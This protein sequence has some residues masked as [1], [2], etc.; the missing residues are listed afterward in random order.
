MCSWIASS[1]LYTSLWEIFLFHYPRGFSTRES[2]ICQVRTQQRRDSRN[3]SFSCVQI[4]WHHNNFMFMEQFKPFLLTTEILAL[5]HWNLAWRHQFISQFFIYCNWLYRP[6]FLVKFIFTDTESIWEETQIITS[7]LEHIWFIFHQEVT[8][9]RLLVTPSFKQFTH[10]WSLTAAWLKLYLATN[11]N[12]ILRC[13][14]HTGASQKVPGTSFR[15]SQS[16]L[17][18]ATLWSGTTHCCLGCGPGFTI[19]C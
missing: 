2:W 5:A 4:Q 10:R 13:R 14:G 16:S 11:P 17:S 1:F 7:I 3:L 19:H 15:G 18:G 12:H 9:S 6:K 8:N